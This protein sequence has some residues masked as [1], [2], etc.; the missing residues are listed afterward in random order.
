MLKLYK[1]IIED[2]FKDG[3]G[4]REQEKIKIAS[5]II[6][7]EERINTAALKSLDGIWSDE[8]FKAIVTSLEKQK[9][10]LKVKLN[11]LKMIAPEFDTY[12]RHSTTLLGN[13]KEYYKSSD[14]QTQKALIGS[15]F[16]EKIYFEKNTYRT[17]KTNEVIE[18]IFNI[19]KDLDENGPASNARPVK[20]APPAGLEPATL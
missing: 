20:F 6:T 3:E 11:E 1:L 13:L 16:P 7:I 18:L 4:D 9:R 19:N 17:T 2:V 8:Q 12:M 15:I 14:Y 5:E 10:N